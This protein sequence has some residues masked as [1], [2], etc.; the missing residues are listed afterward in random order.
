[1]IT[2]PTARSRRRRGAWLIVSLLSLVA[3]GYFTIGLLIDKPAR[4][5]ALAAAVRLF[6]PGSTS[7]GHHQIELACTSCHTEPFGGTAG[8]Q[9][10][11]VRCHG[12]ELAAADDAHPKSKFTDPRNAERVAQ[13]DARSCVPCHVEHKPEITQVMGVT[14]AADFCRHCHSDIERERPSHRGLEFTTCAAGGCHNF[15]D[16]RAL[17]QDFLAQHLHEAPHK[18]QPRL[19]PRSLAETIHTSPNY[20]STRYPARILSRRDNDAPTG[21]YVGAAVLHEWETTAHAQ[22]GV[23]CSACHEIKNKQGDIS[24]REQPRDEVCSACHAQETS[25]FQSGKHGMRVA[26]GLAPM[27]PQSARVPMKR[28]AHDKILSCV[29]CHGAHR[30]DTRKA[31]V[32]ACLGCHNDRH[33]LAYRKGA[34][35]R[36]WA[37]EGRGEAASGSGISCASCHLPRVPVTH[38]GVTRFT[39]QHNQNATLR[40]NEKMLRPVCMHCHG[41]G[42][43]LDALADVERIEDNFARAPARHLKTLSMAAEAHRQAQERRA[44]KRKAQA[45][46]SAEQD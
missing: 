20:P 2:T 43:S 46:T 23:N 45:R 31:A 33:S 35:A 37:A 22:A 11:C 39:V 5:P 38:A 24:W 44:R 10:S 27:Q 9:E 7:D 3:A 16:N 19:P 29:S 32:D 17:Y 36:L 41:L 14:L 30:F 6:L 15:H 12:A 8:L 25:G 26:Q 18:R 21:V 13:L 28:T 34:H 4:A 1:M 40:P 42:L